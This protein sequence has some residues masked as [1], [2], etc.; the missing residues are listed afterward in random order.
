VA[1]AEVRPPVGS[2][3]L[4]GCFEITRPLKLLD[5]TAM[6]DISDGQGS[7]FDEAHRHRLKQAQ[8]LRGLSSRLSKPVMR[9]E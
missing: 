7:L 5:L 9:R 2:K 6:S 4:V 1:L 3:V 8:F